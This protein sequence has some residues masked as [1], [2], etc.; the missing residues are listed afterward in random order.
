[1]LVWISPS[2]SGVLPNE[3]RPLMDKH[4]LIWVGP[5]HAGNDREI[6]QRLGLPLDAV[7]NTKHR[8]RIDETR[9]YIAG[10]SGGGRC[11][12][13]LGIV[14]ADV[15]RGTLA[16]VGCDFYRALESTSRPGKFW[17]PTFR[18]PKGPIF[19]FARQRSRHVLLTGETDANRE[20]TLVT[21]EQG[22]LKDKFQH[23]HYLE[24]PNMGHSVPPVE[25]FD[26]AIGM[27]DGGARERRSD[28][29]TK[30]RRDGG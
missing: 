26:K 18:R 2:P 22:Y 27:M 11:A 14:Y 28:E 24:V 6:W 10:L 5:D 20:Q 21:Y 1:M 13:R 4:R 19:R 25:W 7:H 30:R 9:I 16:I 15:F 17:R 29:E 8:Y 3:W 12:S 23:V